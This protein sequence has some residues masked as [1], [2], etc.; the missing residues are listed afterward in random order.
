MRIERPR[1]HASAEHGF[2]MIVTL[3]VLLIS[4]LLMAAAFAAATGDVHLTRNDTYAKKAYYAA[5]AGIS[6]YAFHLNSDFNYWTYCK[7]AGNEALNLSGES[8]L[9]TRTVPGSTDEKYAIQLL[10]ASTAPENDKKCDVN[11]PV[12]TMIES[13]TANTGTFRIESTGYSG[14]EKR[15]IL[16][17]FA[18]TSFLNY[19]YYTQYETLDPATY[20]PARYQCEAYRGVRPEPPECENI[21]F[22][23]ADVVNGPLHTEDKASICGEPTF[24][25][26]PEDRIEFARGT[27]T[28]GGCTNAPHY[29]GTV[30]PPEEVP[31]IEPPPSNTSLKSTPGAFKYS[32]KTIITLEGATMKVTNKGTTTPVTLPSSGAVVYVSNVSCSKA[33]TPYNPSYTADTECGNVYVSGKYTVPLTIGAENDIVIKGNLVPP[34]ES[35]EPSTN[36]VLGLIAN[37]FVRIYHP[38]SSGSGIN[39]S[40]SE[41]NATNLT[42][43]NDPNKW[44]SLT[45]PEIYAA[46]LA[47]N[48]SFIVD[49]FKCGSPLGSLNLHGALAQ[50]FRGT[51][52][53]HNGSSIASGYS[54]GYVYDNRLEV[55]SP[56]YF[57]NPVDAAWFPKRAVLAPNP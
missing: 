33:Y 54:K 14:H 16:A 51:V 3:I 47:V 17:T 57:L 55:E 50:V 35:G 4:S 56:P 39:N 29:K 12:A 19:L 49:N 42:E 5:Q 37:N 53:T 41:C 38:V 22:V 18:H 40:S 8:P 24:G 23:S 2:T 30:I 20:S 31:T 34:L 15:T 13:G 27:A 46:I 9:K 45:N 25:R 52:G 10:P 32:G 48:H 26:G 43:S 36:A 7:A 6:N 44:G 1:I 21:E 11:N 28:A